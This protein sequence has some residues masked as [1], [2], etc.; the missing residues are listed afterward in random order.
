[1]SSSKHSKNT[2]LRIP[3]FVDVW[4]LGIF[5]GTLAKCLDDAEN[6]GGNS[7]GNN[8]PC[9]DHEGVKVKGFLN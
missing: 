2:M 3:I 4:P 9:L 1:M 6:G 7:R 8:F 5:A